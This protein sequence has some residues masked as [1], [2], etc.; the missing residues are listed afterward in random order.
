MRNH[1]RTK[2]LTVQL[3]LREARRIELH[4]NDWTGD[5]DRDIFECWLSVYLEV[6]QHIQSQDSIPVGCVP[7]VFLI[8]GVGGG[9]VSVG[10]PVGQ[11]PYSLDRDPPPRQRLPPWTETP[12]GQ[13]TPCKETQ[14]KDIPGQRHLWTET[15]LERT[16]DQW[17]RHLRRNNMIPGS[18]TGSD[19]IQRPPFM[20]RITDTCFWK[21]YLIPSFVCGW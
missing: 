8:L 15:P 13:R 5:E 21:H 9:G 11:R 14:E 19:I 16:W 20:N 2:S 12:P 10:R 6:R 7:S 1:G 4:K 18:K 17:Q 3:N